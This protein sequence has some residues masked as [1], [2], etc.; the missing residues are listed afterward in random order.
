MTHHL[1]T[2]C[3]VSL[4]QPPPETFALFDDLILM[5]S[6]RIVFHGRLVNAVPFFERLGFTLPPRKD[7]PSF[8]QE[9]LTVQGQARTGWVTAHS[10]HRST[11]SGAQLGAG[12]GHVRHA[13]AQGC[14]QAAAWHRHNR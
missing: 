1:R 10:N 2:T 8:L 11:R 6:G 7:V 14:L 9:L 13:T 4:L 3:V 12:A 5:A